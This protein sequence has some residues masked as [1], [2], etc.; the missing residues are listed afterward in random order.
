MLIEEFFINFKYKDWVGCQNIN[1]E[2][3]GV[4]AKNHD[5][6]FVDLV[7]DKFADSLL[8]DKAIH[9]WLV[10][11]YHKERTLYF[12]LFP[13]AQHEAVIIIDEDT[14]IRLKCSST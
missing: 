1:K 7:A 9:D 10:G 5:E 13:L 8:F 11:I 14:Y 6:L 2:H 12:I 4:F 3:I